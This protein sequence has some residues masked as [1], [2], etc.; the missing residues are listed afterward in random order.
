MRLLLWLLCGWWVRARWDWPGER[1]GA[2]SVERARRAVVVGV[3]VVEWCARGLAGF[4][5]VWGGFGQVLGRN[6]ANATGRGRWMRGKVGVGLPASGV[7]RLG[8]RSC[9]RKR[10]RRRDEGGLPGGGPGVGAAGGEGRGGRG[11]RG[12]EFTPL[13]SPPWG[14]EKLGSVNMQPLNILIVAPGKR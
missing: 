2:T 9:R 11:P 13:R 10:R 12:W 3:V 14:V 7:R 8:R 5:W 1:V 4:P 6:P